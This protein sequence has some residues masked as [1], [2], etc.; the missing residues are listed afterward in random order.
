MYNFC[1]DEP[2]SIEHLFFDCIHTQHLLN[3]LFHESPRFKT[4][5]TKIHII[6]GILKEGQ[7]A[8]YFILLLTK[9]YIYI[10]KTKQ[11]KLVLN[12][13]KQYILNECI[14]LK[15][16]YTVKKQYELFERDFKTTLVTIFPSDFHLVFNPCQQTRM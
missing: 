7:N 3:D 4:W 12:R 11:Q 10:A 5:L 14:T 2:E 6:F 1:E 15:H 13:F 8:L 9:R 16:I